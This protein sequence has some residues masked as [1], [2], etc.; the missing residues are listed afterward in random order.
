MFQ[1]N[2]QWSG[3][4]WAGIQGALKPSS[5]VTFFGP[6]V[7]HLSLKLVSN[8]EYTRT[9]H[10]QAFADTLKNPWV[11]GIIE[12]NIQYY[13]YLIAL[14]FFVASSYNYFSEYHEQPSY[15]RKEIR[16]NAYV[17]IA[18]IMVAINV[19]LFFYV[20]SSS[21][22]VETVGLYTPPSTNLAANDLALPPLGSP[23][24]W[25]RGAVLFGGIVVSVCYAGVSQLLTR[26]TWQ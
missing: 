22:T 1:V 12:W 10:D 26:K 13:T 6:L 17:Y 3:A 24:T 8:D 18:F 19:V 11:Y 9:T 14:I 15:V 21:A 25:A 7:L 16:S 20:L 2:E 23:L 5:L 4:F